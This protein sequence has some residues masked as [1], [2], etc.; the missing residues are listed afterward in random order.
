M[1]LVCPRCGSKTNELIECEI[2]GAI[3]CPRCMRKKHGK[4]V[5]YKCE[6]EKTTEE[7]VSSVFSSMFG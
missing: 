2:C 5:C 3:G 7:E 4:W 1:Q 6:K